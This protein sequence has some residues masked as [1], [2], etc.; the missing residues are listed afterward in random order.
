MRKPALASRLTHFEQ[1]AGPKGERLLE[2]LPEAKPAALEGFTDYFAATFT[3]GIGMGRI[4]DA[5]G[6]E[7]LRQRH[8]KRRMLRRSPE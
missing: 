4:S 8:P 7:L 2:R 1:Q 5:S 6:S 3:A